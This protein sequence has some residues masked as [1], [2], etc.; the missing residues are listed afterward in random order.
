LKQYLPFSVEEPSLL[1]EYV[2]TCKKKV[3]DY[4]KTKRRRKKKDHPKI[5]ALKR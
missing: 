1:K 3:L 4:S 2:S 5:L